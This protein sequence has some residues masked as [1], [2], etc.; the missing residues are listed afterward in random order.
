MRTRCGAESVRARETFSSALTKAPFGLSLSKPRHL[1]SG[2]FDKLSANG[3]WNVEGFSM[4]ASPTPF[5]L[6]LSKPRH[7]WNGHLDKL[8]AN[9]NSMT[10]R[11]SPR[12]TRQ[13]S[14]HV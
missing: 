13:L 6:S 8:S 9:G 7:L 4:H 11:I 14:L 3:N 5:G 1:W 10:Q 12:S 2:H